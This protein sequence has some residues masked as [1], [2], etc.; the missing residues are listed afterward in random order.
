MKKMSKS[1]LMAVDFLVHFPVLR[2][3]WLYV[4]TQRSFDYIK[5]SSMRECYLGKETLQRNISRDKL[6]QI[7]IAVPQN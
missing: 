1:V 3:V 2:A 5:A 6:F 4:W 7:C